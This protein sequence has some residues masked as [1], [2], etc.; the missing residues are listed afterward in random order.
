VFGSVLSLIRALFTQAGTDLAPGTLF[1][2]VVLG[3]VMGAALIA[4]V[5]NLRN[6]LGK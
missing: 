4:V 6:F 1:G 5:A 3:G 2:L